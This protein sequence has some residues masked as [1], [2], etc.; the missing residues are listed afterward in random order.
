MMQ[1][2]P[3]T[4]PRSGCGSALLTPRTLAVVALVL[5]VGTVVAFGLLLQMLI[6]PRPAW[7]L[8]ALALAVLVAAFAVMK[9][10]RWLPVTVLAVS[11]LLLVLGGMY[12]F[13]LTRVPTG[14]SAF[15]VG[16]PAPDFALPDAT[17]K[18]VTLSDYRG[19]QPVVLVFYRGYW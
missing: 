7:Y 14:P 3:R 15:V 1:P 2:V 9:S 18:T 8:G 5:A 10:R 6:V 17:G 4:S 12:H 13:V 11:G 16:Q 19:R